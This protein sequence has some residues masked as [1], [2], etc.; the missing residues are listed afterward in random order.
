[1]EE[2]PSFEPS[3]SEAE[4]SR[5][6]KAVGFAKRL[7]IVLI[8]SL[9]GALLYALVVG[10]QSLRGFSDG[11]FIAGAVLLIIGLLPLIT[12]IFGRSTMAF[13]KGD[14]SLRDVLDEERERSQRSD[15]VSFLFGIG[16]IIVIALS[17]IIG[18]SLE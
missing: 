13:R 11:L 2:Q 6:E 16:G 12:E 1:M 7:G 18:F 9:A 4:A 5:Q 14:R 15:K 3:E 10:P 8:A 17:F